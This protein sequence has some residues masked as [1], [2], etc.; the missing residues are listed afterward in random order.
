M[1]E[2]K[3]TFFQMQ[4][5]R[6]FAHST[7]PP[8]SSFGNTPKTIDSIN[9]RRSSNKLISP[10]TDPIMLLVS[11]IHKPFISLPTIRVDNALLVD[12]PLNNS[13]ES[14]SFDVRN[15]LG[16]NFAISFVD[17]KNN[18]FSS[19]STTSVTFDTPSSEIAFIDFN[20]PTERRFSLAERD[21]SHANFCEISVYS[22]PV[23]TS[24]FGNLRS[25]QIEGEKL[26]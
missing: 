15:D 11:K 25:S 1:I 10:M 21:Y 12:S 4:K 17:S 20:L 2:S 22:I 6:R 16:E 14:A 13:P 9:V 3:L 19:R 5:E 18:R 26:E 23:Q 8:Q 7:K 24:Y